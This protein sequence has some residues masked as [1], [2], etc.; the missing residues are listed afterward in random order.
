VQF[1]VGDNT[2]IFS[3]IAKARRFTEA[4][5]YLISCYH[6]H[7]KVICEIPMRQQENQFILW[8]GEFDPS[9]RAGIHSDS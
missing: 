2:K 8:D 9:Q 3:L 1:I 5:L 6:T 7:R 4:T